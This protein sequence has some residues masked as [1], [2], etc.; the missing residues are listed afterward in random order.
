MLLRRRWL[1]NFTEQEVEVKEATGLERK[2]IRV[3]RHGRLV[4]RS[5]YK[6]IED[7]RR[8]YETIQGGFGCTNVSEN[9]SGQLHAPIASHSRTKQRKLVQSLFSPV[10]KAVDTYYGR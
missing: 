3:V 5:T 1:S 7:F 9:V 6:K 4:K 2:T 10:D 8:E